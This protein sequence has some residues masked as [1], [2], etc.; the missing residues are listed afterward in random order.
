MSADKNVSAAQLCIQ[1]GVHDVDSRCMMQEALRILQLRGYIEERF[2]DR[3][4]LCRKD[5]ITG[6]IDIVSDNT[7][8]ILSIY[9]K[10]PVPVV[11][12]HLRGASYGDTVYAAVKKDAH[13]QPVAE[14]IRIIRF[15]QRTM[16]GTI[17]V[18]QEKAWFIPDQNIYRDIIIPLHKLNGAEDGDAVVIEI[19]AKSQQ[20]R[21][22]QGH[23]TEILGKRGDPDLDMA[24]RMK[25]YNFSFFFS[26]TQ[27]QEAQEVIATAQD[28]AHKE[29]FY[30]TDLRGVPT[31]TID[32]PGCS[33][34]DD[35]LSIRKMSNGNLEIGV[36]IVDIS[37]YL[38]KDSALDREAALRGTCVYLS[39]RM[40]PMLPLPFI[41]HCSLSAGHDKRTFSVMFEVSPGG[42]VLHSKL[43]KTLIC[44]Q[45]QFSYAEADRII[46]SGKGDMAGELQALAHISQIL[47]KNRFHNG[48]I[49]FEGRTQVH[50]EFDKHEHPVNAFV[51]HP[52]RATSLIEEFMLL[53]NRSVAE[54]IC[55]NSFCAPKTK[56]PFIYR[57]H[58]LPNPTR[59]DRFI[60][61]IRYLGYPMGEVYSSRTLAQQMSQLLNN[62]HGQP[63]ERLLNLLALQSMSKAR[64]SAGC[65]AHYALGFGSYTHFTSPLRRYA[66]VV[67][68]RL[69]EHYVLLQQNTPLPGYEQAELEK[70]CDYLTLQS[71]KAKEAEEDYIQQKAVEYMEDHVGELFAAKIYNLNEREIMIELTHSGIVGRVYIAKIEGHDCFYDPQNCRVT[72]PMN[73]VDY[74]LGDNVLVASSHVDKFSKDITF[75]IIKPLENDRY[76]SFCF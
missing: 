62:V 6:V 72:N 18:L 41:E 50:F 55:K 68:H 28:P 59:F 48:A 76:N 69:M 75:S 70:L 1:L 27:E 73:T 39:N 66:D 8:A 17:E 36:H 7:P 9:H 2:P 64:Y 33:D 57:V 19:E 53:A 12:E 40:V 61:M 14:V 71:N 22:L 42:K 4:R 65:K 15:A 43:E 60:H 38:R 25:R 11:R 10:K 30:R 26:A 54:K 44:S 63:D 46:K 37:Y 47:R 31:F 74:K 35:A 51:H 58:G 32:P 5:L 67:V 29:P 3:Y 56:R 24:I 34:I 21:T 23:V 13:N 16:P 20:Q 45:R 52:N 49:S